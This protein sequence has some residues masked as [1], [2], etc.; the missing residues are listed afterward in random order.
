MS[1]RKCRRKYSKN[2]N[3]ISLKQKLQ[4]AK[5]IYEKAIQDY[6]KRKEEKILF[7]G[8]I[9]R[10]YNFIKSKLNHKPAITS[11]KNCDGDMIDDDYLIAEGFRK[12]YESVFVVDDGTLPML[13]RLQ[14]TEP[15][16]CLMITRELICQN[17]KRIKSS[18]SPGPD[19]IHPILLKR[20]STQLAIPLQI[21]FQKSLTQGQLPSDW[22]NARI[23]P[24]Y[25]GKG[26]RHEFIN[27][28]PVSLTSV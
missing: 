16:S 23:T 21:I 8:N 5:N 2:E 11:M 14:F 3:D 13:D 1:Y 26:S 25:K 17:I 15:H 12:Q 24:V 7:S 20:F 9:N 18:S 10:F 27:Y 22:K 19:N 6:V 28:R 4:T